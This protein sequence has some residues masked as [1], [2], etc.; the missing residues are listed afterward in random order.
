[1]VLV[2]EKNFWDSSLLGGLGRITTCL[3]SLKKQLTLLSEISNKKTIHINYKGQG[4]ILDLTW[5]ENWNA[6]CF[7]MTI[8]LKWNAEKSF[9]ITNIYSH[10]T[11][12]TKFIH[13]NISHCFSWP[14]FPPVLSRLGLNCTTLFC[15]FGTYSAAT[16]EFAIKMQINLACS[17]EYS[18]YKYLVIRLTYL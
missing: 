8:N 10:Y 3:P 7:K 13:W 4:S 18:H 17:C 5:P 2:I 1:M 12:L 6:I 11:F 14:L 15:F 9:N 16:S